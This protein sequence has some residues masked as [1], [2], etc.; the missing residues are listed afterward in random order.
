MNNN[1]KVIWLN[2]MPRSGTSWL[3][4]IFDSHPDTKYRLAPLFSF[5]FKNY[6]NKNSTTGKWIDF[7]DQVYK[8]EGDEFLEQANRRINHQYPI[9]NNKR[10]IPKNLVLKHTRYHN[11]TNSLLKKNSDIKIIHIVRNPCAVIN[12]WLSAP[13]EFPQNL[14]PKLE[15]KTGSCRKTG[16]EEFWGF[17]DWKI[18]TKDY[19]KLQ[20]EYPNNILVIKYEDLVKNS[21]EVTKKM[22]SFTNLFYNEQTDLFLHDCHE[23]H[24]N[25]KYAVFK[26]KSVKDKWK[27]DLDPT[28]RDEIINDLTGTEYEEFIIA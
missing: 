27:N 16:P 2:G 23:R 10:S 14:D 22:F 24:D 25:N 20:I 17:N 4:Q 7:F 21:V 8:I 1:F 11:L 12:S 9:F 26:N 13:K 19:L 18:L 28:I 3:G 6:I 5:A 15:W